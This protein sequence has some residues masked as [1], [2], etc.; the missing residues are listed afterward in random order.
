[1]N[2]PSLLSPLRT[3]PLR[4]PLAA[5]LAGLL[6]VLPQVSLAQQQISD[7]D[8]FDKSMEAAYEG[9]QYYGEWDDEEQLE[10]IN[11]IGYELASKTRFQEFPFTFYLVDMPV[12][13]AF[14]LPGGQIFL[15]RSMLELGL[16]DDMLACLLGHEIAHVVHRHG[17]RMQKRAT[18]LSA[19]S[20]ALIL[21]VAATAKNN[22]SRRDYDPYSLYGPTR[23]S[24]GSASMVEG[25]IATS[26]IVSQLLLLSYSREFETEADDEGQR[27]AAAAGY[28]PGGAE[29]LWQTML[30]RIPLNK[31][32]GYWRTHPFEDSR[33]RAAEERAKYLK[34]QESVTADA[35]RQSVQKQLVDFTQRPKLK[36]EIARWLKATALDAWPSG[37][38]AEEIRLEQLDHL[39]QEEL[40]QDELKRDYGKVIAAYEEQI[41]TVA[42]LTP[43]S[44]F[45]GTASEEL[46]QLRK[47]VKTL[48]PK[49]Q[50]V[51]AGDVYQTQFLETF[52]SNY[53]DS[54]E[55]PQVAL[56][57]GNAYSRLRQSTPAVEHYLLAWREDPEGEEGNKARNGLRNLAPFL[58]ELSA[59]Q[60]LADMDQDPELQ[61]IARQRL[62]QMVPRY[63]DLA[64]GADYLKRFPNGEHSEAV[65][66]RLN[67]LADKALTEVI[68]YQGV[69]D[70]AKA[71]D[72]I[73]RIFTYAP[74]SP[75]AEQLRD[76]ATLS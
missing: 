38:L 55:V 19:L 43:R 42:R 15:A 74:L 37:T 27:L 9:L 14:A 8:L 25:A 47:E 68:V 7:E 60:Q 5:L 67:V 40:G 63:E 71:L 22:N 46:D 69:G 6:L 17:T 44:T 72:R 59:L 45:L 24:S 32:Y 30:D 62:E 23:D 64:N 54:P 41:A 49:A 61:Q 21:G 11:R 12:P 20:T 73:N 75:A 33:Q 31:T 57:L 34:V 51:L 2:H 66:E 10:R 28:D 3:L 65:L 48:Y 39:R 26:M 4:Q 16:D 76:Q 58:E 36:P 50:E 13:N 70:H 35:Y 52:L 53:P 29:R 56:A 18:L 1:M